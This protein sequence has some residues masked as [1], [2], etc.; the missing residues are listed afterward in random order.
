MWMWSPC[1]VAPWALC[2]PHCTSSRV[3]SDFWKGFLK[4][5][6]LFIITACPSR[7]KRESHTHTTSEKQSITSH[8]LCLFAIRCVCGTVMYIQLTQVCCHNWKCLCR[9]AIYCIMGQILAAIIFSETIRISYVYNL[10]ILNF[11]EFR[12]RTLH[13]A[14][15][16]VIIYYWRIWN[17]EIDFSITNLK[18][19]PNFP[20]LRYLGLFSCKTFVPL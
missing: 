13:A 18:P 12:L 15:Q 14:R 8:C 5:D 17:L 1:S 3:A 20:V 4:I 11:G 7:S 19:L 16:L 6:D 2:V 10:A 9:T